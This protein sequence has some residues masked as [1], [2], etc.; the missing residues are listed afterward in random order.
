MKKQK[1]LN[2][3]WKN[4]IKG[5]KLG[6]RICLNLIGLPNEDISYDGNIDEIGTGYIVVNNHIFEG[7]Q[8]INIKKI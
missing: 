6:D 8:I 7:S 5:L 2:N 1:K 3:R 4:K